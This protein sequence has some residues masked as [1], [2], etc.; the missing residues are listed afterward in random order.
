MKKRLLFYT[1]EPYLSHKNALVITG[2]RQ[3]GKTT[4]MRQLFEAEGDV[5]KVWLD[6]DNPLEQKVLEGEDFRQIHERLVGLAG[7]RRGRL[8]VYIDEVQNLPAV[9]LFMKYAIDHYGTKFIVTGSSSYY[10]KNL[11]PESLSGR[12]FLFTL[13][14]MTFTECLYF[15]DRIS[16][17]EAVKESSAN[18]FNRQD[19]VIAS[20]R[21]QA[22]E[23]YLAFG[24]FPEVVLTREQETKKIILANILTSFFEKD[25]RLLADYADIRELR[26]LLLLLIPRVGQ[27]LDVSK[28]A[29]ELGINRLK[30]YR[31]LEFLQGTFFVRLIPKFTGSPDRAVAGRK[32][33]YLADTGLLNTLG[34]VN[35]GQLFENAVVNQLWSRGDMAYFNRRGSAE[36]DII[37]SKKTA[38]EVKLRGSSQEV[39]RLQKLSQKLGLTEAF[40]ISRVPLDI[41]GVLS[42]FFW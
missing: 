22:Y 28:V 38:L 37:F 4:L 13:A 21:Q 5:P 39:S 1:L 9:T 8:T 29:G 2:M 16:L 12:K 31:Y 7:S 42:P 32:K 30:L 40:V 3:V 33:I 25:V 17:E 11:F 20:A 19:V 23:E 35:D 27:I 18:L 6:L 24:G 36:I 14:P 41:P 34:R 10:L 26:D 15:L